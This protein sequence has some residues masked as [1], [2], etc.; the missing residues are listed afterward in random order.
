M[1]NILRFSRG[2]NPYPAFHSCWKAIAVFFR[3][4]VYSKKDLAKKIFF[5]AH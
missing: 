5:L 2:Q 1:K 4:L 3:S